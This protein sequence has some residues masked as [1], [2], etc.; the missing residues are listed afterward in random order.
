MI[1]T[2]NDSKNN[3]DIGFSNIR[4][5]V[6]FYTLLLICILTFSIRIF[7]IV[8]WESVTTIEIIRLSMN[9]IHISI[10]E[11]QSFL[12]G[13]VF[14]NFSTGLTTEVGILWVE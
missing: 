3:T 6:L 10:I 1:A 7:S 8:Q 13:E 4:A 5:P 9:M 11:R 14:M 12:H 2:N